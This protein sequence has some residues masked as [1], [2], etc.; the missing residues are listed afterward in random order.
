MNEILT[1]ANM[2]N[3]LVLVVGWSI[4]NELHHIRHSIDEAKSSAFKAHERLDV[5][6]SQ[7]G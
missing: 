4:R 6:I 5:H 7:H 2:F 3:A 1:V